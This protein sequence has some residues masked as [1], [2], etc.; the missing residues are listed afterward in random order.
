VG[1]KSYKE[2]EVWKKGIEIVNVVYEVTKKLPPDERYGLV[3][4]M[5]RA[6][7]SI[8]V[9]VAE[10]FARQHT[11]EFRQFCFVA[12]GS[13]A[14]LETLALIARDRGYVEVGAFER[15][16]EMLDHESR[17]LSSLTRRLH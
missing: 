7:V 9:N 6:A 13:C 4:Q 2:L 10:G 3:S 1:I 15:L 16:G 5:Q 17:M 14:E 12:R 11:K 8:P